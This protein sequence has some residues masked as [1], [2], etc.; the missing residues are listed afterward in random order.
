MTFGRP[1]TIPDDY[2][3]LELPLNYDELIPS[4][5]LFDP[6]RQIS[7]QFFNATM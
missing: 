5:A 7:V 3:R 1:A 2:V 6:R 4:S